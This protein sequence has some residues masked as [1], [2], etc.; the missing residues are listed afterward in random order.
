MRSQ[1]ALGVTAMI[2]LWLASLSA[3]AADA[4]SQKQPLAIPVAAAGR[5][6]GSVECLV[7]LGPAVPVSAL[8][9]SPDGKTLAVGGYQEVL[10]WDLGSAKL[11]KRIGTS[12]EVGAVVFLDGKTLVVGEGAPGV[13]GVVRAIDVA[14]GNEVFRLDGPTDV[15]YSLAL[16]SD[17]KLLAASGA[18]DP[19][20]VWNLDEKKL[21]TTIKGHRSWVL[22][23]S[24]SADGKYLA[25][26]GNDNAGRLWEVGSWKQVVEFADV[27]PV[28]GSAF[29][30]DGIQ[31]LLAVGGPNDCGLRLRR[32]DNPPSRRTYGTGLAIPLGMVGPTKT[33][34]VYV[35][36]TDKTV[37]VFDI[38]NG[39]L[40]ATLSGHQD[41][42]Y[43]AALSPDETK[44]ASG[45]GDGT[46][47]LWNTQ[48]NRLLA[49]LAQLSPRADE[50][51][52]MTA[53]G[54]LATSS[55]GALAWK[56]E[57]MSTPHDEL[58]KQLQ[59]PEPVGKAIAG[60]KI[61]APTLK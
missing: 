12:G 54:Y 34:A 58:V 44:L 56:A 43:S 11:A 36:C 30:A 31:V 9:F 26:G 33:N 35:P 2:C 17:G 61:A 48:D 4:P 51:L 60:E 28:R 50:W 29:H 21:A 38:T 3:H 15:V 14:T 46:V 39:R 55:P 47:K 16:S 57:N 41:W 24:F 22:D 18:Y 7:T 59:S 32:T 20:H 23:V 25:T 40:L 5:P 52:I 37:K 10:L 8:A 42:V 13:S 1:P 49:T 45:S 27:Q 19:V 6:A 53:E